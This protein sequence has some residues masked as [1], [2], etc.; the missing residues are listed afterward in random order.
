M[1]F[2]EKMD[3]IECSD[4]NC[5]ECPDY[6]IHFCSECDKEV[7]FKYTNK[8]GTCHE[9]DPPYLNPEFTYFRFN[10][11]LVPIDDVNFI[12]KLKLKFQKDPLTSDILSIMNSIQSSNTIQIYSQDIKDETKRLVPIKLIFDFKDPN[13]FEIFIRSRTQTIKLISTN[14]TIN[15]TRHLLESSSSFEIEKKKHYILLNDYGPIIQ[16]ILVAGLLVLLLFG[17]LGCC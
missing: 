5:K 1:V 17:S 11:T 8:N 13:G 12:Y 9:N 15:E 16:P 4:P 3:F 7:P 2:I 6:D 10:T 14:Y